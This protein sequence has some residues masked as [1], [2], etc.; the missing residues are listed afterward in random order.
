MPANF[1]DGFNRLV[2]T[3]TTAGGG[4]IWTTGIN[5]YPD[6]PA[7]SSP[8]AP[9]STF[10]D[11]GHWA[12]NA[13]AQI[14]AGFVAGGAFAAL[15]TA[16]GVAGTITSLQTQFIK[17]GIITQ[18]A[19]AP[20]SLAGTGQTIQAPQCAVVMSLLTAR[21]GK[22]FRGRNFWPAN[23]VQV[24]TTSRI[25]VPTTDDL[26]TAWAA[27]IS[28]LGS[29]PSGGFPLTLYPIVATTAGAGLTKAVSV[30]VGNVI[31]TQRRRRSALQEVRVTKTIPAP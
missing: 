8:L 6:D 22:R 23:N 18:Q 1:A 9:L 7:A 19:Q 20:L 21:P 3:G 2:L 5:Y 24:G 29:Q 26:A 10:N 31:D 4:D 30:S 12:S 15:R 28:K 14:N 27:L 17:S 25:I 13:A 16:L 11:L